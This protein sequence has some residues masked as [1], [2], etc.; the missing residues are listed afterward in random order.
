M[1]KKD[2]PILQ[3]SVHLPKDLSCIKG[4]SILKGGGVGPKW[5]KE[6]EVGPK[7]PQKGG[8]IAPQTPK[9]N[10]GGSKGRI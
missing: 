8:E 2:I 1:T 3:I 10:G 4:E 6:G 7:R 9:K 5:P